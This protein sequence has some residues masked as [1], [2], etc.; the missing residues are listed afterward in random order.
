MTALT[1]ANV[2]KSFGATIALASFD[3]DIASGEFVSLLGPSGCGKTTALRIVAGFETPDAGS[4]FTGGVDVSSTPAHRRNMGM[5]FQS[6]SLFPNMNVSQ[7][8]EFGLRTRRLPAE[9]RKKRIDEALD[10]VQ[11]GAQANRYAHQLSGGQQ[12]RVALARALAIRPDVLLL[13]E[14]LSALD[15]KVRSTLRDEI[16]RIQRESGT[17]T[18]FVTH[19]Q[20]EALSISDR[21]GVMSNGRLEQLDSPQRVY[22][23]PANA[24]VAR[25]VGNINEIDARVEG[26]AILVGDSRIPAPIH[27]IGKDRVKLLVRPEHMHFGEVGLPAI[28]QQSLFMGASKLVDVRLET[29]QSMIR[30]QLAGHEPSPEP[31]SRV[32]VTFDE[33]RALIDA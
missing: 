7:N 2:T 9:E 19:D 4:V 11:L 25:F 32:S 5:V 28:V 27:A 3:L 16:K 20:D 13:D 33:S 6:Y 10:L 21:V 29:N 18:V 14:P 22:S 31:G 8:I 23:M 30:V 15:A 26:S 17:T 12:Q 24:F 1:L